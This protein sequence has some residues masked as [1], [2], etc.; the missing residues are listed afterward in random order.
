MLAQVVPVDDVV[1]IR[2]YLGLFDVV[3]FPVVLD[4]VVF[5]PAVAID[6]GT[7][8]CWSVHPFSACDILGVGKVVFTI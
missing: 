5:V 8:A 7:I 6:C 4:Q 1:Q 3:L 2:Q